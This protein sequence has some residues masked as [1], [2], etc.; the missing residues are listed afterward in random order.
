MLLSHSA[1]IEKS[2]AHSSETGIDTYTCSLSDFLE[3]ELL[4]VAH[5]HY[6]TL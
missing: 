3:C 6:F 1:K 5:I 4:I 2:I